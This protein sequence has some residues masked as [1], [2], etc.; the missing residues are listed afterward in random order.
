MKKHNKAI[1]ASGAS[2]IA[3]AVIFVCVILLYN[4]VIKFNDPDKERYP[5][6]G[7]DVS[8][9]Q[10]EIDFEVLARQGIDFAFIKATE[11]SEFVDEYF[12]E[13]YK[14]A[15]AAGIRVGAYHFFSFDSVGITQAE[16]FIENVPYCDGMLPPVVDVELYGEYV[17]AKPTDTER[18]ISELHVFVDTL[19]EKY[20]LTPIIY[21]MYDSYKM[22]VEG[23]FEECDIWIRDIYRF[24]ELP[25][26]REWRF[27]QYSNR[28]RLDGYNGEEKYID[29][30][31]F[32]GSREDFELYGR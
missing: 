5:V 20:G 12:S 14:N 8:S 11:G 15:Q 32:S 27:W 21:T 1:I 13:N 10:G 31:V 3:A 16:N 22:F 6:R 4:G 24:P 7:V 30:N 23:D 17:S 9:Y 18:I 28:G 25:D 29:L 26:G 2:I 19:K